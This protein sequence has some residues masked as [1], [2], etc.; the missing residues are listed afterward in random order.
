[1]S[2]PLPEVRHN[3]AAQRFEAEVDG[4]LARADY[5]RQGDV[6]RMVHTEVPR[7][8]EGRGIAAALVRAAFDH[9]R[10]QGLR[11]EPACSYVATYMRRHAETQDLLAPGTTL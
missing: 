3:T 7:A 10:A 11:I 9:A 1:M 6:M 8:L 2:D 4:A 5:K